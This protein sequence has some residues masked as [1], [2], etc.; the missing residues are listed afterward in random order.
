[1]SKDIQC[2]S[3]NGITV[4]LIDGI[5]NSLHLLKERGWKSFE[6]QE[7]LKDFVNN[8][9]LLKILYGNVFVGKHKPSERHYK[10]GTILTDGHGFIYIGISFPKNWTPSNN[11]GR[12]HTEYSSCSVYPKGYRPNDDA[13]FINSRGSDVP[14]LWL[15]EGYHLQHFRPIDRKLIHPEILKEL[16]TNP[17]P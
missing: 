14:G 12:K 15:Q 17:N 9:T 1:M 11:Y 3:K 5:I 2:N 10:S 6:V 4:G 16:I 13:V 7:A 8:E